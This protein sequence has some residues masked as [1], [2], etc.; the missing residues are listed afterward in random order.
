[1]ELNQRRLILSS[2][3]LFGLSLT[4]AFVYAAKPIDLSH[5][6]INVLQSFLSTQAA[7]QGA[8]TL[9]EVNRSVDFNK[10]LHVRVKETYAGYP[11][12]GG[13]AIIHIPNGSKTTQAMSQVM[14][15]AQANHGS[16]DGMVYQNLAAD[17]ANTPAI[18]FT[19]AQAEKALQ[20]GINAYQHKIGNTAEIKNRQSK[21]IVFVDNNNKAH[22]AYQVTF[23]AAPAKTGLAP[24][25]PVY[26][27]DALTFKVYE[28]WNNLQ[29]D[30]V[31]AAGGG[32]GGNIKMGELV[33]D[34]LAKD[35]PSLK[36]ERD[37]STNTC[38]LQNADVTVSNYKD[39]KVMHF[40]CNAEDGD[41][42]NVF[43]DGE[44]D[45][46][47]HGYS[48]GN[49]ALFGGAVIKDMYQK[50]YNIP[51]LVN[52]DGSPMML[53]M[54]VHIP[55]YDNAYWDG[56][57]MSFGDG[58]SMFYPLTSL[59][60][61][62]HEISHGFTEQ[63]SNLAYYGKSGGM[64]EAFSDMAAQAAEVFAYGKNSWQIG[65]EIFKEKDRALRYMDQ[66]SK[67]CGDRSPGDW[68]SIDDASQYTDGL[69]VHYSSGVYNRVFYL[70]GS[71]PGWDVK[72]AF[73]VMV[74]AN[75][76]YWT[77]NTDFNKGACGVIKA[78]IDHGYDVETVKQAFATVKVDTSHC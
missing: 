70:M 26:I 13:E 2:V 68:C 45:A 44:F 63:H 49:D 24:A 72:K 16:L 42:N 48:P 38:F 11:V 62:A 58:E 50:W 55:N 74:Q 35:L 34:G 78:T 18:V 12:W 21:L 37:A 31:D 17:L 61:A 56:S 64:N 65:P 4:S 7:A 8:P 51:V 43:W 22:W 10:T 69:D 47:N 46:V 5:Q 32:D 1:M 3:M 15:A 14:S 53:N 25:M 20:Q 54:V 67:D 66:P 77:S 71:A 36:I 52:D 6:N 9:K 27:M 19:S 59:G 73:D 60:V 30:K 28:E 40:A 29:T 76:H 23:F 39:S 41:H 57:K 75:S 33:Y